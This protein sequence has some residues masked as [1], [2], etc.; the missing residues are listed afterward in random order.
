LGRPAIISVVLPV[1]VVAVDASTTDAERYLTLI[2]AQLMRGKWTDP[3]REHQAPGL[4]GALD[5]PAS[6]PPTAHLY[7]WLLGKHITPHIGGVTLGKLD[8]AFEFERVKGIEPS[9]SA[10]ESPKIR[11]LTALAW[12]GGGLRWPGDT[13]LGLA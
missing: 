5:R 2:E 8:T 10:W 3:A 11:P 1:R 13:R 7:T 9:L 12:T 6:R 4:R